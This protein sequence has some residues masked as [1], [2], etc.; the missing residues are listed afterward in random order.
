MTLLLFYLTIR[1][2]S[3]CGD[4]IATDGESLF[5]YKNRSLNISNP[6]S[7]SFERL[8]LS[9][10]TGFKILYLDGDKFFLYVGD[11]SRIFQIR[12]FDLSIRLYKEG[13]GLL[14]LACDDEGRILTIEKW[15]RKIVLDDEEI[16]TGIEQA[17]SCGFNGAYF[18]IANKDRIFFLN[19]LMV[20]DSIIDLPPKIFNA[21]VSRSG[22]FA[23]DQNLFVRY[24]D[25]WVAESLSVKIKQMIAID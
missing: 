9:L 7:L 5:L 13:V 1:Q 19:N 12:R 24:E 4:L 14:D 25:G 11:R 8:D 16:L 23:F 6:E 21:V 10:P 3:V 18:F 22:T 2:L 17:R 20:A 15:G